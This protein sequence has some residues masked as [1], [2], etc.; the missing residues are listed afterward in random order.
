MEI[1]TFDI[2]LLFIL[3]LALALI[4]GINVLYVVDKK[5]GDVQINVPA[6]PKPSC[7]RPVCPTPV[8][9]PSR[10]GMSQIG[11]NPVHVSSHTNNPRDSRSTQRTAKSQSSEQ[12]TG[13]SHKVSAK[14]QSKDGRCT[15]DLAK[16]ENIEGFEDVAKSNEDGNDSQY[17]G[18]N[19]TVLPM[20]I[21]QDSTPTTRRTV[22]LRQGYNS[23]GADKP[24]TGD[25]ITYP[26]DADVVRYR[27]PGCY[28]NIDTKN[29]RKLKYDEINDTTCRPYTD[30]SVREE[31]Y[32]DLSTR[33]MTPSSNDPDRIV[34]QDIRFY[35]PRVYMGIDPY[36]AGVSYASMSLEI[37]ADIDQIGSIPVNDYDGEPVP[38]SAFMENDD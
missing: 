11:Q 30:G 15:V 31:S 35:V 7:P 12:N 33:F 17:L 29:V 36:M 19:Q 37:P 16:P 9:S 13:T 38:V 6:C 28:Q 24:N 21:T 8:C 25:S 14:C 1:E 27:G 20:V 18:T 2:L 23:T 10:S 4:I 34:Q 26:S 32:N 5:L 22:L 3:A